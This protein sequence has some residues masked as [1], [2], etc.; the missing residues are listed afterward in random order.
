M[1]GVG[2]ERFEQ[3]MGQ[4]VDD[5]PEWIAEHMQ[6]VYITFAAWPT[7]HQMRAARVGRGGMLLGLYEG[8]PLSRRGRGYHLAP[9]DRI[10]LFQRPLEIVARDEADLV[11]RIQRTIIHEIAHHFGFS[12]DELGRLEGRGG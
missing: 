10:T 6:N 4:A 1:L 7:N 3:L 11:D 9:P 8:V 5:L 2:P 12:E